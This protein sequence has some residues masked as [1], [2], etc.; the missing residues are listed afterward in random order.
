MAG[1]RETTK[2]DEA[3]ASRRRIPACHSDGLA[4]TESDDTLQG[5]GGTEGLNNRTGD[6]KPVSFSAV[7]RLNVDSLKNQ[8]IR[9]VD[10]ESIADSLPIGESALGI[11][12][13]RI[14]GAV[15]VQAVEHLMPGDIVLFGKTQMNQPG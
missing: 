11:Q 9:S 3:F 8:E 2:V 10:F 13:S 5:L 15:G 7:A 4:R 1:N 12:E 14:L 6:V